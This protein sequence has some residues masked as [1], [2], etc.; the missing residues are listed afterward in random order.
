VL[1]AKGYPVHYQ[2]FAGGHDYYA[3]RGELAQ[4]LIALLGDRAAQ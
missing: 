2:E 3:W 4:G 1:Q